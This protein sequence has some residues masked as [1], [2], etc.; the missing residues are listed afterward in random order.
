MEVGR[1]S[2]EATKYRPVEHFE[3]RLDRVRGS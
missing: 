1:R 2:T 3:E